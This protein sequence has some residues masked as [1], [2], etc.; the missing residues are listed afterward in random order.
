MPFT[1]CTQGTPTEPN[2]ANPI[3]SPKDSASK[4]SWLLLCVWYW[5][6]AKLK[7]LCFPCD[8]PHLHPCNSF[9]QVWGRTC[10]SAPIY[11]PENTALTPCCT[12]RAMWWLCC[13]SLAISIPSP[14]PSGRPP[15]PGWTMWKVAPLTRTAT[16]LSASLCCCNSSTPKTPQ[17]QI[18]DHVGEQSRWIHRENAINT[19][20]TLL[21]LRLQPSTLR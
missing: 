2:H 5:Q 7:W 4:T 11:P 19:S 15:A 1:P 14:R 17:N 8:Q 16:L 9:I 13:A 18:W 6:H 20:K 10:C 21:W 3:S 12:I